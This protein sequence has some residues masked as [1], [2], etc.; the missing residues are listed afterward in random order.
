VVADPFVT[1]LIAGGLGP[2]LVGIPVDLAG[3]AGAGAAQRLFRR[4]RRTDDL[5]RLVKAA[6]ATAVDLT[7]DEF[8]AVRHLL[9]DPETWRALGHGTVE[10]LADRIGLCLPPRA[11]RTAED[12]HVAALIIARGLLE[13][14]VADLDPG[15]FQKLLLTRLQRMDKHQVDE[16]DKAL[17]EVQADLA[18]GFAS[19]G[20]QF[21]RVLDRL[22]PGPAQRGEIAVYLTALIGWLNTDPWPQDER[23]RGSVLTPAAIE[24]KLRLTSAGDAGGE[25]LDADELAQQC[26][27]LVILG[28]PGSGK[29]WL[30]KRTA[31]RCAEEALEALS[32][33]AGLDDVELPLYTTCSRLLTATGDPRSAAVSSAL[34]Y[35]LGDL[36]G[37]RLSAAVRAFFAERNAPTVLVID[38]LDEA[39]GSGR[40][41]RQADT[42]PWRIVLTSRPSS[43]NHHLVIKQGEGSHRIGEL[44]PLRYPHDVEP[45]IRRWFAERPEWGVDLAAQI[46]RRPDLQQAATVPLILA[47]YCIIGGSEP[48]PEFRRDLFTKVLNRMLTGRWRGDE[49]GQPDA[50]ACLQTLRSW[51]WSGATVHPVSRLGTWADD[52]PA[53][54]ARLHQ[55][56]E[57]ALDHVATPLG[58]ADVDTAMTLRR[59]IHRS[60]REHLVA[61]HIADLPVDQAAE[62]LLPHLWYD[63]DWEYAAPAAIA[64]H[65]Q[66]DQLLQNLICRAAC[67]QQIPA[68]L[69][70]IDPQG[71]FLRL[72]ARVAAES[73]ED[74][75]SAEAAAMIGHARVKHMQSARL[76]ELVQT[77]QTAHWTTSNR[78]AS[79]ALLIRIAGEGVDV[80]VRK[81]MDRLVPLVSSAEDKRHAREALLALPAIQNDRLVGEVLVEGLVQIASSAE[82][83]QQT[84]E[85][86][87][88]HLQVLAGQVDSSM[89]KLPAS[90]LVQIAVSTED[91]RQTREAL[92]QALAKRDDDETVRAL[93]GGLVQIASS[94][95]DKRQTREALL[96]LLAT[97][98]DGEAAGE[99]V[100]ALEDLRPSAEDIRQAQ[101]ARVR[102]LTSHPN[103]KAPPKLEAP[104]EKV[105][106]LVQTVSSPETRHSAVELMIAVLVGQTDSETVRALA[107]GLIRIAS[108]PEDRSQIREALLGLLATQTDDGSAGELVAALDELNTSAEDIRQAQEARVGF[109][110]SQTDDEAPGELADGPVQID[111]AQD[112]RR[113]REALLQKLPS[114]SD[115][116]AV[117]ELVD[118]LYRLDQS[119]DDLRRAREAVLEHIASQ[120]D[121]WMIR[122]LLEA[123]DRL[124]PSADDR[125]QAR[126]SLL[127]LIPSQTREWDVSSLVDGLVWLIPTADDR[128]QARKALL[129]LLAK[130][131]STFRTRTL[132]THTSRTSTLI[133]QMFR[134]TS[135]AEDTRDT[136]DALVALLP[137]E[138]DGSVVSELVDGLI[139]VEPSAEDKNVARKAL[140]GRL[141]S[142][143]D[144]MVAGRLIKVLAQLELSAQDKDLAH[145]VLLRHLTSGRVGRE[146]V[147]V[148]VQL[149]SSAED[150]RQARDA[151]LAALASQDSSY[152]VS[153]LTRGLVQLDSSTEDKRQARDALLTVL[154]SG[155]TRELESRGLES[156]L[157]QMEP[158]VRDLSTWHA[159]AFPPSPGLLAAAR[160]NS[161]LADWLKALPSLP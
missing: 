155:G 20:E 115:A 125:R 59:F 66:H 65:P 102:L 161:T 36:G 1:W 136:R 29:T 5:S 31:R 57:D 55:A 141:A 143:T 84:R 118:T 150:K 148:L 34:D 30:A 108:S 51:A 92:V 106:R 53:Q 146:L 11:G 99:L 124:D 73:S 82:D 158:T 41:L 89:V 111:P 69:S 121:G 104:F 142:E 27:R 157:A 154:A 35:E 120:V 76:H 127:A 18:A 113:L 21:K 62:I 47:F 132:R 134:L 135:S 94:A 114:A 24:R 119:E 37:S 140:L 28:G 91:R 23:F 13:L 52:F 7:K 123:L 49:N 90:G 137:T 86:L 75:W 15:L 58:Y 133:R 130:P 153:T 147:D 43:W 144:P 93:A 50:A 103:V 122:R 54:P 85:A 98:T 151:L 26:H 68:D 14:A 81:L 6:S 145:E 56:D 38:S 117:Y 67:S 45:F 88:V 116:D 131:A 64:I 39:Q 126:E 19:L 33:G 60:I 16:L 2:A 40:R 48:L 152:A 79:E 10:D 42:L 44:R 46:V 156:M 112:N 22:S 72:L 63:P 61:E 17:F 139:Q 9:E 159:W 129:A 4:L 25:D 128:R 149:A 105:D 8:S 87:L 109:L 77:A 12:S 100:A 3:N 32:Q 80:D 74:D 96:R 97:Q 70:V 78:Q 71:E 160:Q 110:T 101:E 95:E 83:R 138:A 107:G